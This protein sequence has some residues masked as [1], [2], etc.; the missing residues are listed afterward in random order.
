VLNYAASQWRA[1]KHSTDYEKDVKVKGPV[2]GCIRI[3]R[4]FREDG[5]PE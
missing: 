5:L 2:R 1:Y 4:A 3:C